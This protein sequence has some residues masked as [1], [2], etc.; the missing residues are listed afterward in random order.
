M[1]LKA[2]GIRQREVHSGGHSDGDNPTPQSI[3]ESTEG[4]PVKRKLLCLVRRY[5]SVEGLEPVTFC[6]SPEV[7]GL[8]H[9]WILEEI[10][11]RHVGPGSGGLGLAPGGNLLQADPSAGSP[12]HQSLCSS[13]P[14]ASL[15]SPALGSGAPRYVWPCTWPPNKRPWDLKIIQKKQLE[16]SGGEAIPGI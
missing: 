15:A 10:R 8:E 7:R 9:Q 6:L 14:G 12:E 1:K 13:R 5:S 3:R 16:G 2:T 11:L 4:Y